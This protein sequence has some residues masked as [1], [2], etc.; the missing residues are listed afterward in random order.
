MTRCHLSG[1]RV[2]WVHLSVALRRNRQDIRVVHRG[3]GIAVAGDT[4]RPA[5]S[6]IN[7]REPLSRVQAV[8]SN[9]RVL[10]VNQRPGRSNPSGLPFSTL[11]WLR[12]SLHAETHLRSG[13]VRGFGPT[14]RAIGARAIRTSVSRVPNQC[15]LCNILETGTADV[16]V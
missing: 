8:P 14:C 4:G 9:Y 10:L 7:T 12:S 11:P 6:T 5:S 13:P 16:I 3:R 1:V 2:N 15:F